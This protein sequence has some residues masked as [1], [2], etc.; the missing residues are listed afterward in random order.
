MQ[1][2]EYFY[3]AHSAFAYLG[4]RHF[5]DIVEA[6]GRKIRHKPYDLRRGV[7]GVGSPEMRTPPTNHRDY[8]FGREMKRWAQERGIPMLAWPKHHHNDIALSNRMLIAGDLAGENID[9]LAHELLESHWVEDSDLADAQTLVRLAERV[10]LDGNEL[11]ET[12]KTDI[13]QAQYE[14]N[15]AEAIERSVFG[16]PTYFVDG[17]MFYGQDRLHMV[18]RAMASPYI[19]QWPPE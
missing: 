14:A 5:M 7:A 11:L 13:V 16:S 8:F 15:T 2:I 6:T 18:E 1:D 12:A 4:S 10:G 19:G 9:V 3:S 17:D